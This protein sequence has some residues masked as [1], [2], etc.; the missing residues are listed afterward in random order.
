V[1]EYSVSFD[2]DAKVKIEKA[3][4]WYNNQSPGLGDK[5]LDLV[6][7][8]I[9]SLKTNPRRHA[10]YN[11]N[12][13]RVSVRPYPHSIHYIVDEHPGIVHIYDFTDDRQGPNHLPR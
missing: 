3:V 9:D 11:R 6:H 4:N 2:S 5:F 1:S 10:I 13:R 8:R 12:M 7:F